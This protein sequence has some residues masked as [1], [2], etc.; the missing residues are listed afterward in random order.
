MK[1]IAPLTMTD[2]QL[3]S[4]NV[5]E[6]DHAEWAAGTTYPDGDRV[7]VTSTHKVYESAQGSNTGNDPTTDDG[8]WWIEVGST[9]RWKAFDQKISDRVE[10]ADS[11]TY[12]ITPATMVTGLAFFNVAATSIQIDIYDNA[13]TPQL[14]TSQTIDLVDNTEVVDWFTYF[15]EEVEYD[16]EA[17]F[18]GVPIYAG[19]RVDITLTA[20]GSTA[21]VGQIVLGKEYTIGETLDGTKVGITDYSKKDRD[22]YGNPIIV[23]RGYAQTVTFQVALN[24]GDTRRIQRLLAAYRAKP[25]VYFLDADTH[26]FGTTVYGFYADFEIPLSAGGKSFA[27]LEIEGLV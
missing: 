16:T 26:D 22:T 17:I 18:S 1:I 12:S 10:N 4:S 20:T 21:R 27:T 19:Y 5:T 15:Y 13:A 8:T 14:V 25:A 3:T 11:I 9:N 2:A 7:I 24:T 23:E 6:D